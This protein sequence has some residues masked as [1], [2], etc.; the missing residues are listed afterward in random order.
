MCRYLLHASREVARFDTL[1]GRGEIAERHGDASCGA[2]GEE[3]DHAHERQAHQDEDA[4][5]GALGL[6]DAGRRYEDR[7]Q[8][9]VLP[10]RPDHPKDAVV[11]GVVDSQVLDEEVVRLAVHL[12]D[13]R[14]HGDIRE[15]HSRRP[16]L[17][18]PD[19]RE[20][21]ARTG[22]DRV[23]EVG[24]E[25]IADLHHPDRI[26][27]L[28]PDD[29]DGLDHKA[30]GLVVQDRILLRLGTRRVH[31]LGLER[32]AGLLLCGRDDPSAGV[33]HVHLADLEPRLQRQQE[34]DEAFAI[35][36]LGQLPRGRE[37]GEELRCANRRRRRVGDLGVRHLSED[38]RL[39]GEL[40]QDELI[41]LVDRDPHHDDERN[42]AHQHIPADERPQQAWREEPLH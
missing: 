14:K 42:D 12:L 1:R 37:A 23:E 34:G 10:L 4:D 26:G 29:V 33:R 19:E 3:R 11:V 9:G 30:L 40:G 36:G 8:A 21:G 2:V 32:I 35:V 25:S 39:V 7:Q 28:V 41:R 13:R 20:I 22:L 16:H 6:L 27:R 18:I 17:A 31:E 5:Q 24:A 38:Q 15:L